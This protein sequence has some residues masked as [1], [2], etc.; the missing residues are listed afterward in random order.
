MFYRLIQKNVVH[1]APP[2]IGQQLIHSRFY[3]VD[4]D[5]VPEPCFSPDASN[6]G[7][8]RVNL[9]RVEVKDAGLPVG[10]IDT[11]KHPA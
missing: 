5:V 8:L 1:A 4:V 2:K 3:T 11:L 6:T 10:C 7:L 9:P